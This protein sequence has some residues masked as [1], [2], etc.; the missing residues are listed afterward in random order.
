MDELMKVLHKICKNRGVSVIYKPLLSGWELA[1]DDKSTFLTMK[2]AINSI[3]TQLTI[4]HIE[5]CIYAGSDLI[6]VEAQMCNCPRL[7]ILPEKPKVVA[8]GIIHRME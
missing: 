3:D 7:T 4:S 8:L 2:E 5:G 1:K 6:P